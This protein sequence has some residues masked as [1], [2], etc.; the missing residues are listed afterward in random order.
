MG[1]Y[2]CVWGGG[3]WEAGKSSPAMRM[4]CAKTQRQET[5]IIKSVGYISPL[6]IPAFIQ[7]VFSLSTFYE[8]N[9]VRDI[10]IDN[11]WFS[12]PFPVSLWLNAR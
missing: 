5:V 7:Q 4:A 11:V 6:F 10:K 3:G 8:T 12:V 9:T 2:M 1:V